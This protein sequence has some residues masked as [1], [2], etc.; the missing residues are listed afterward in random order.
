MGWINDLEVTKGWKRFDAEIN[1]LY[2]DPLFLF[3]LSR[4]PESEAYDLCYGLL[5]RY[6]H[7]KNIFIEFT[8]CKDI[9]NQ[10]ETWSYVYTLLEN[11]DFNPASF[12]YMDKDF[13]KA[14][15]AA[16]IFAFNL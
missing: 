8:T 10:L 9:D 16:F 12:E 15:Q 11:G 14:I 6:L 1:Q 5:I 2:N 13:D 7:Q 3:H 4:L